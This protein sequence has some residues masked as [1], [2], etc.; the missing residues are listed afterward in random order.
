MGA[1][2]TL[3]IRLPEELKE[4]GMQV[5]SRRHISVSEA[6]RQLFFELE[7]SQTV[8]DFIA[9]TAEADANQEKRQLLRAMTS[10]SRRAPETLEPPAEPHGHDWREDWHAHLLE[11]HEGNN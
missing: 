1:T 10:V 7:R 11:K 9:E 6:V 3:N 4:H 5:L 2:A 8:P